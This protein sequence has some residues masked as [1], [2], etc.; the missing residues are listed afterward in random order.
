MFAASPDAARQF[1]SQLGR[2]WASAGCTQLQGVD[3]AEVSLEK[4]IFMGTNVSRASF[5]NA[6]LEEAA[7]EAVDCRHAQFAG[8]QLKNARFVASN[9]ANADFTGASAELANFDGA[10]LRAASFNRAVLAKASFKQDG[11]R[12]CDAQHAQFVGADL[13]GDARRRCPSCPIVMPH[14]PRAWGGAQHSHSL[15]TRPH[16]PPLLSARPCWLRVPHT[17]RWC[18]WTSVTQQPNSFFLR[19]IL[20]PHPRALLCRSHSSSVPSL[21]PLPPLP[22]SHI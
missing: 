18:V 9:A 2:E 15:P 12:A 21:P 17:N 6:S 4:S 7:F 5:K 20:W 8:A 10:T 13:T 14:V 16:K 3:L 1:S 19:F 22:R 11:G